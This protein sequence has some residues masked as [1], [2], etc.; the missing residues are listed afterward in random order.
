MISD[1]WNYPDFV[2]WYL[3][4]GLTPIEVGLLLFIL[5]CIAGWILGS[6]FKREDEE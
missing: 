2:W 6:L 4:D 5:A 1:I 3:F